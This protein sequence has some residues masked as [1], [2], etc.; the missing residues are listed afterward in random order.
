MTSIVQGIV[1]ELYDAT[2][3]LQAVINF[4]Y[5]T[6]DLVK[7]ELDYACRRLIAARS[8]IRHA[9]LV[10]H[11]EAGLLP[12]RDLPAQCK[13]FDPVRLRQVQKFC[14]AKR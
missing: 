8:A 1:Q 3:L 4:T 10:T 14:E 13:P 12:V 11:V 2:T 5:E 9:G 6:D 7:P